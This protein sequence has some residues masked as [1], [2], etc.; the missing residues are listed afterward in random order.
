MEPNKVVQA[1]K[2][3]Q[4]EGREDLIKDGVLEQ[5]WVGLRRPKRLS[6][7]G[8][9]AAVAACSSPVKAGKKFRCKSATGRK[10]V[11]SPVKTEVGNEL[12]SLQAE[13]DVIRRGISSLP[14]RQGSSLARRAAALGGRGSICRTAVAVGGR[15]GAR[16]CV[17]HARSG[18]RLQARF[19]LEK[20][21]ER[22]ERPFEERQLGGAFK[23]AAPRADH[24]L[25]AARV[26]SS[27]GAPSSGEAHGSGKE[28]VVVISSDEEEEFQASEGGNFSQI[29]LGDC[30]NVSIKG[31]RFMQN[32]PRVVSPMLNKV[33][34]WGLSNQAFLQL[35]EKIEFV[36]SSGAVFKG[37][38]CGEANRDV[39]VGRAFISLDC[40]QQG[41]GGVPAGCDTS[42]AYS[43]HGA[44]ERHPRSGR[45]VGG[46]S[47]SV[48]VRAPSEHCEEGRV[49]SG[50]VHPTSGECIGA[51]D[52]Q[53]STSQGAGAGWTCGDEELLDYDDEVEDPVTFLK[54]AVVAEEA[55]DVTRGGH[56]AAPPHELTAGNLPRG[57]VG[58]QRRGNLE[59]LVRTRVP[60][61]GVGLRAAKNKV[62][63]SIQVTEVIVEGLGLLRKRGDKVSQIKPLS[64]WGGGDRDVF[65]SMCA[66]LSSKKVLGFFCLF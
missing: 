31:G 29:G 66:R 48:K 57:E 49:R 14:R 65:R 25:D 3:L 43:G 46:Q 4:D 28:S 60:K 22:V 55:P 40:W 32:I 36:D 63:A 16:M 7:E 12:V 35:G 17:A 18:A 24:N 33:Q 53:P 47:L 51:A 38:V 45:I 21:A 8:V 19:H 64:S 1:L 23:M 59:V 42:H 2:V 15:R 6:A 50:A 11:H 5:A 52:V 27:S 62:D 41:S 37:T 56:V 10:V 54:R 61:V 20:R 13:G 26:N 39:S 34:A 9:S 30:A 58:N 44:Q